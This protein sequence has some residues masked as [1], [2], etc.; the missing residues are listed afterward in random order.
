MKFLTNDE[1]A[2]W[3]HSRS[4]SLKLH[5]GLP[6][7]DVGAGFKLK[8]DVPRAY[9]E[10]VQL[11]Y[12]LLT[13]SASSGFDGGLIWLLSWWGEK[14]EE[15]VTLNILEKMREGCGEMRDLGISPGCLLDC[16]EAQD[17]VALMTLPLLNTW[18]VQFVPD[19]GR[20]SMVGT[21]SGYLYFETLDRAT[22][23][24]TMESTAAWKPE[25]QNSRTMK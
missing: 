21:V 23:E 12:R 11:V 2:I 13:L 17:A 25:L 10:I 16:D 9:S 3:C 6:S 7:Y 20:F 14:V 19:S 1:S 24:T 15:N 18:A 22:I 4:P 8:Y 5:D